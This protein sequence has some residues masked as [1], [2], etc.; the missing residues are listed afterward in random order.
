M[1]IAILGTGNVGGALARALA[2]RHAITL[3]TRDAAQP[4]DRTTALA[5]HT[6]A[7]I[8]AMPDAAQA[9]KVILLALPW[10]ALTSTLPSL[11]PLTGKVVIDGTNPLTPTPH[12]LDLAL[13][14]TTSG[15]EYVQRQLPAAHV[16]K[17]LNQV[18]AEVM[19]H[20][21]HLPHRPVQ[22]I[23]GDSAQAKE[24]AATLLRDLGFDPLDAGPLH[25]ARL[26]EPF[27]LLWINQAILRGKGRTWAF[28]AIDGPA[29]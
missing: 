5:A 23:A 4:S 19:E 28:A 7:Q 21:A 15:A 20:N 25:R 11:G 13:G 8:A 26:L 12:G 6:G 9:A 3:G 10:H 27:A 18:G 1:Q 17:T 16:V 24:T 2:P 22:F 14:H 29:P